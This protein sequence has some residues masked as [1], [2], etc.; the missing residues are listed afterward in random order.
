MTKSFLLT[1]VLILAS[2]KLTSQNIISN[3]SFEETQYSPDSISS[4][5]KNVKNWSTPN[6]GTTDLFEVSAKNPM[7]SIPQNYNGHQTAKFGKKYAGCYFLAEKNYR[8]YIQ[9]ELKSSLEKGKEYKVSFYV[10]LAEKSKYA[11]RNISFILSNPRF[12]IADSDYLSD[13]SIKNLWLNSSSK[14]FI[15]DKNYYTNSDDWTLISKVIKAKGGENYIIIGNFNNDQKTKKKKFNN[16]ATHNTSYY[17][18]DMVSIQPLNKVTTLINPNSDERVEIKTNR[19][20]IRPNEI[21]EE[22]NLVLEKTYVLE[23]INFKSNS[24]DLNENAVNELKRIFNFL[25]ADNSTKILISGHTDDIGS[26]DYNQKL[27][28]D[29]AQAIAEYL[30]NKGISSN[31]IKSIGYGNSKPIESNNTENGRNKN[32]RVEF[33]ITK[34]N[35]SH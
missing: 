10:S 3:P 6:E 20:E 15:E 27:S 33:K 9:G 31:R 17:Y 7:I 29:R 22:K 1:V 35:N 32:R 12:I 24:I 4:F 18:I 5:N 13:N 16:E 34:S 19:F 11:L 26:D 23:N 14:H 21:L 8:E 2:L 25:K 28:E 30:I